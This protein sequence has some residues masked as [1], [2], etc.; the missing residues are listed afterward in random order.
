MV[1]LVL[2]QVFLDKFGGDS[3]PET[4]RN[5]RGYEEQVQRF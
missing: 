4:Q 5:F 3:M 1:A 2:T